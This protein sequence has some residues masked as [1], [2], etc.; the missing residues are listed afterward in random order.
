MPVLDIAVALLPYWRSCLWR[1]PSLLDALISPAPFP[2]QMQGVRVRPKAE[3]SGGRLFCCKC[4]THLHVR[5]LR[6]FLRRTRLLCC[7][8]GAHLGYGYHEHD[9]TADSKA[10]RNGFQKIDKIKDS[11]RQSKQLE[12]LT[13][14]MRECKRIHVAW[15]RSEGP[16]H[17]LA[18][19][20]WLTLKTSSHN[21]GCC[22]TLSVV[23]VGSK[24]VF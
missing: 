18:M 2:V 17:C 19:Y 7:K 21:D 14:K 13:G 23:Y 24:H 8:C 11:N 3:L 1:L 9:T 12:E 16:G 10:P 22:V 5:A 6:L 4:G 20:L 15:V